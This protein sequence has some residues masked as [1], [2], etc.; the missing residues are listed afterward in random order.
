MSDSV[1]AVR[2]KPFIAVKVKATGHAIYIHRSHFDPE[3]HTRITRWPDR[4]T[5]GR[6]KFN[7]LNRR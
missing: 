5:P 4:S 7:V 6:S 2:Q 1:D 3:R